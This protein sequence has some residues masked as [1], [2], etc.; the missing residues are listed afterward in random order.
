MLVSH[1]FRGD[2]GTRDARVADQDVDA[3]CLLHHPG[4]GRVDLP[5]VGDL[6]FDE[7]G[8]VALGLHRRLAF[9]ARLRIAVGDIDMG[10]RLGQRLDAG[11]A[12][13]LPAAGD[14]GD[15]AFEVEPIEIHG[16][17]ASARC[18]QLIQAPPSTF[19]VCAT[20]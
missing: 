18:R 6:H 13:P 8:G 9:R 14:D 20:T 19:S 11:E 7:V 5:R 15:A 16:L 1:V 4:R 12:D 17:E 2:L 3:S 10:A